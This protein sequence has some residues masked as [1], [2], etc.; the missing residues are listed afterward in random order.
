MSDIE[1]HMTM[2]TLS[3]R[4]TAQT[5]LA[6]ACKLLLQS[7]HVQTCL[8]ECSQNKTAVG[9]FL[10]YLGLLEDCGHGITLK[11]P[12]PPAHLEAR[13]CKMFV[14]NIL[15]SRG[16]PV[17]ASHVPQPL[18]KPDRVL[19]REPRIQQRLQM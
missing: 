14:A 15:V 8:S 16:S 3:L 9:L 1:S 5:G 13:R 18:L 12:D 4:A 2:F 19:K 11:V 7:I 6:K 17:L 10:F